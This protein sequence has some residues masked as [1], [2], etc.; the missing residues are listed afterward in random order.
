MYRIIIHSYT[1]SIGLFK[2]S[3]ELER[4]CTVE[5]TI[6]PGLVS[7]RKKHW[8]IRKTKVEYNITSP[9]HLSL[10]YLCLICIICIFVYKPDLC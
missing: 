8:P 1:L 5:R 6:L 10:T 3:G 9:S 4:M 7:V 2:Q